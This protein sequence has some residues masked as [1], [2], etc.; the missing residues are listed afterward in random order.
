MG[1][2]LGLNY[3]DSEIKFKRIL[4]VASSMFQASAGIIPSISSFSGDCRSVRTTGLGTIE[5][6]CLG[7]VSLRA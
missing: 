2:N 7:Q 1:Y 4:I 3:N 6:G 5:S